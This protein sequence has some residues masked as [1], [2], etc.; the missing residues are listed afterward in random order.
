MGFGS[1]GM[2]LTKRLLEL[3]TDGK[4]RTSAEIINDLD[5]T[6]EQFRHAM[7]GAMRKG[8]IESTPVVYSITQYGHKRLEVK[9]VLDAARLARRAL[10][11]NYARALQRSIELEENKQIGTQTVR[12]VANSVFSLGAM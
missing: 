4:P 5:V 9:P 8:S 11:Q 2:T 1:A 3:L 10:Q 6:Y 12:T 7:M